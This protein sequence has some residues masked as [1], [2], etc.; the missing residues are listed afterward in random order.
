MP[1]VIGC[2]TFVRFHILILAEIGSN[3]AVTCNG[4]E[5]FS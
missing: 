4:K 3:V 2:I 1:S 5:V